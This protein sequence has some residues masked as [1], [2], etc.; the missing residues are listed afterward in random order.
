[1]IKIL[2]DTDVIVDF[3]R[4]GIDASSVFNHVKNKKI[5]A[6]VS[7]ITT[8]KLYNG[9]LLSSNPKQKLEDLNIILGYVEIISFDNTQSYVA[10]KIYAYLVKKG[11]KLEMRDILIASCAIAKNM[12]IL[13]NNKKHFNRIPELQ[14]Y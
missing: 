4:N 13:T 3:L 9:A 10:S 1:M 14:F 5:Q 8:F 7:V 11:I 6:F 2:L 12:K